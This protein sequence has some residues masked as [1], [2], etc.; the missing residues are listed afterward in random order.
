M[1]CGGNAGCNGCA[2]SGGVGVHVRRR[3][4]AGGTA[5]VEGDGSGGGGGKVEGSV[6]PA[7]SSGNGDRGVGPARRVLPVLCGAG[8]SGG[9]C[10][11]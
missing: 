10:G 3:P 2:A 4:G 1:R 11:I 9:V 5:C 6:G 7:D 8:W